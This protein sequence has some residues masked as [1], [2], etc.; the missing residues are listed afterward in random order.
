METVRSSETS[1]QPSTIR[2]KNSKDK[3]I[4]NR[5][6][7]LNMSIAYSTVYIETQLHSSTQQ[8]YTLKHSAF[9]YTVGLYVEHSCIPVCSRITPWNTAAFQYTAELHVDTQLH[10]NIQQNYTLKHSCIPVHTN[11]CNESQSRASIYLVCWITFT[12]QYACQY[13]AVCAES[14]SSTSTHK[15]VT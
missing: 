12:W 2:R 11:I 3:L 15:H 10:S 14:P 5:S 4:N 7:N 8:D 13:T 1:G 9:Q 6:E